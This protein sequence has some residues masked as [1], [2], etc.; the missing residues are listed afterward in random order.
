M[1]RGIIKSHDKSPDIAP[2]QNFHIKVTQK[3][4]DEIRHLVDRK[5]AGMNITWLP[6]SLAVTNI[7][8][9][10]NDQDEEFDNYKN[11]RE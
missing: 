3:D 4:L 8:Q 1:L 11:L 2:L 7:L 6:V 10:I 9:Q 5:F